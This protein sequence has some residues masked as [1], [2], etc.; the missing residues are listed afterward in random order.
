MIKRKKD[1]TVHRYHQEK[2][3]FLINDYELVKAKKHTK[4]KFVKDFYKTHNI[5]NKSFLKYYN[6]FKESG[7]KEDLFPQKR[8][9]KYKT[10]RPLQFIENKVIELRV[11]GNN[12]YEIYNILKPKLK[13]FTPSPAGV[14]NI[15]RRYNLNR[16]NPVIKTNRRRIIKEK[17]GELGHIDCH[18]LNKGII[19][20]EN[21][22]L[23]VL[24]ILDDCSRITWAEVI[25]NIKSL[26]V[27]FAALKCLN[28]LNDHYKIKFEEILSDNGPEFGSKSNKKK[29]NHPFEMLLQ[30]LEIKHIY[31]RIYK[32][33][34]NGKIERFWRTLED[35]M[36]SYTLYDSEKELKEELLQYLYY[37]NHER[38]HQGI[39]GETPYNLLQK[40]LP[41]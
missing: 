22:Q 1:F 36:L 14:Y 23:Y 26:T 28:M 18:Y 13:Q 17:I 10:R 32:P 3:I 6:R 19:K 33:Q 4:F 20:G 25:P 35:D 40:M 21:K 5:R 30:E 9:P 37:Y 8:G 24:S 2:F 11:K 41:N 38:P 27:M 12:R 7:N 39:N 34:T 16:L 15:L 31:T 29:E